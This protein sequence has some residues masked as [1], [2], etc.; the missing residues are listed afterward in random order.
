[1]ANE[2]ISEEI[3]QIISGDETICYALKRKNVK[4]L[5]LRI[6]P[7]T[8]VIV[9]APPSVSIDDIDAFVIR[10]SAYISKALGGIKSFSDK[11]MQRQYVSGEGFRV[12]GKN[13]RLKVIEADKNGIESDGIFLK[14]YV[15][16]TADTTAK[17][18]IVKKFY[19][20]KTAA[21]MNEIL[22]R[23]YEIFRKYN[24]RKPILKFRTMQTRW[25]SCSAAKGVITLNP[26][27][28]E[29]PRS[30]I[31]YVVMHELCHMMHPNH[32]HKFYDFLSIQMPDWRDRK[33]DLDEYFFS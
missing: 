11:D 14:L 9:S 27:L 30:C 21:V 24:V 33:K 17:E 18:R 4:K 6:K 25:G 1:M 22:D 19:A 32:S 8:T 3:R 23:F 13:F 2:I 7:D 28:I 5:N 31:E 12:G 29:A 16:D 26:R 10:K 20:D 15:K